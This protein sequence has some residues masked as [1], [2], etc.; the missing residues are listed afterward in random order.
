MVAFGAALNQW[1]TGHGKLLAPDASVAQVDLDADAI[2]AHRAVALG[3]IG[4]A[5]R[6]SPLISHR[7]TARGV[8]VL[9]EGA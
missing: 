2:G 6:L 4:D 3:V 5:G 1:T 8:E 9:A 7:I